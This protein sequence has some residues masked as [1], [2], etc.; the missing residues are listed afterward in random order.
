VHVEIRKK[1]ETFIILVTDERWL[2]IHNYRG[3]YSTPEVIDR[4]LEKGE[5][6]IKKNH[7]E[8]GRK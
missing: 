3:S 7:R 8:Q 2:M 4:R 6:I 5:R 1:H